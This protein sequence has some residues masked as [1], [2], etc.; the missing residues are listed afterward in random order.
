[1]PPSPSSWEEM[2]VPCFHF[3]LLSKYI[4]GGHKVVISYTVELCMSSNMLNILNQTSGRIYAMALDIHPIYKP[5]M[6]KYFETKK[7]EKKRKVR[8]N[9]PITKALCIS[10]AASLCIEISCF[11]PATHQVCVFVLWFFSFWHFLAFCVFDFGGIYL[12]K[13]IQKDWL[14]PFFGPRDVNPEWIYYV[15]LAKGEE[16]KGLLIREKG[17]RFSTG[18]GRKGSETNYA[19]IHFFPGK[20][21]EVLISFT[22]TENKQ[23]LIYLPT[24]GR[25]GGFFFHSL[26]IRHCSHC[27]NTLFSIFKAL[28]V[29]NFFTCDLPCPLSEPGN[30]NPMLYLAPHLFFIRC[31]PKSCFGNPCLSSNLSHKSPLKHGITMSHISLGS[32]LCHANVHMYMCVLTSTILSHPFIGPLKP[33]EYQFAVF[34]SKIFMQRQKHWMVLCFYFILVSKYQF[35]DLSPRVIQQS[36]NSQSLCRLQIECAKTSPHAKRQLRNSFFQFMMIHIFYFIPQWFNL[37]F[38]AYIWVSCNQTATV[39]CQGSSPANMSEAHTVC[40]EIFRLLAHICDFDLTQPMQLLLYFN[41]QMIIGPDSIIISAFLACSKHTLVSSGFSLLIFFPQSL[42]FYLNALASQI[43]PSTLMVKG[44]YDST[45]YGTQNLGVMTLPVYVMSS[46]GLLLVGTTSCCEFIISCSEAVQWYILIV[47]FPQMLPTHSSCSTYH[48]ELLPT[49][50]IFHMTCSRFIEDPPPVKFLAFWL[51]VM[52]TSY[53]VFKLWSVGVCF[54]LSRLYLSC[55]CLLNYHL[56]ITG[57]H[58]P[59]GH[60]APSVLSTDVVSTLHMDIRDVGSI[61]TGHIFFSE[62]HMK[63]EQNWIDYSMRTAN[64]IDSKSQADHDSFRYEKKEQK[65]KVIISTP[66][67]AHPFI[68]M[69][70]NANEESTQKL[71]NSVQNM[72]LSC[73]EYYIILCRITNHAVQNMMSCCAEKCLKELKFLKR[74]SSAEKLTPLTYKTKSSLQESQPFLTNLSDKY[75]FD[76]D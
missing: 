10:R 58:P 1:M 72:I 68:F 40:L 56:S 19:I 51:E 39:K 41:G 73:A 15:F 38:S 53:K 60:S 61:P 29:L 49:H 35:S 12:G 42:K 30:E 43:P 65:I 47:P 36:S 67:C 33:I 5:I 24:N 69:Y 70:L 59:N 55:W 28:L 44:L 17:T 64:F 9:I 23:M 3:M 71:H 52:E 20:L 48:V 57:F 21:Q 25:G 75:Y 27:E 54:C 50:C 32:S 34:S 74:N 22:L 37:I 8:K 11:N 6:C 4:F 2:R 66:P 7:P 14:L 18:L 45:Q 26:T 62:F 76:G 63:K 31:L 46:E 13:D 16:G